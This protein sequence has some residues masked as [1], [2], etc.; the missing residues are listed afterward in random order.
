LPD[1]NSE[2]AVTTVEV[3]GPVTRA[4]SQR[5]RDAFSDGLARGRGLRIDL[6]GS[7]PWDLAGVQLLLATIA[8][9][10]RAGRSISLARVPD[11]LKVVAERAALLDRLAA[12]TED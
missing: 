12:I 10:S 9:G 4:E 7:G 2:R 3:I 8:S 6:A 1:L 11:V 5:W